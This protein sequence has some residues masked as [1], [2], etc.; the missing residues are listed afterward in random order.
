LPDGVHLDRAES[1]NG[2]VTASDLSG[3][4]RPELVSTNGAVVAED[5]DGFVRLESTNGRVEA[6]DVTGVD[7][8]STVNGSVDVEVREV[9]GDTAVESSQGDVTVRVSEGVEADLVLSATNGEVDTGGIALGDTES[10]GEVR[11]SL[12]GGG[13][14]VEASTTNGD[15]SLLLLE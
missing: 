14:T 6:T 12:G 15:V 7:G 13:P 5:I 3:D 11:G 9:R 4:A 8:A 1:N 2:G 10:N